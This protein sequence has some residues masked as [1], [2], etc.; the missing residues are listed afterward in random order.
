MFAAVSCL[1]KKLSWFQGLVHTFSLQLKGPASASSLFVVV[2]VVVYN[3]GRDSIDL[4]EIWP[5]RKQSI[6]CMEQISH[7]RW[8]IK[9]RLGLWARYELWVRRPLWSLH[10][11]ELVHWVEEERHT[12]QSYTPPYHAHRLKLRLKLQRIKLQR[13]VK[14]KIVTTDLYSS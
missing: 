8:K 2:V 9:W 14:Q 11:P 1:E 13:F 4:F 12:S 7:F 3:R 6:A 10:W 5:I